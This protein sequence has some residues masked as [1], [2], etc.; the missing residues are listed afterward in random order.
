MLPGTITMYIIR[1]CMFYNA[2]VHSSRVYNAVLCYTITML[3]VTL[4][5]TVLVAGQTLQ[6][7]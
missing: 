5:T 4:F 1:Y 6:F 7:N 3:T 2:F